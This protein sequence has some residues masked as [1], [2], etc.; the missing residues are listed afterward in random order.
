MSLFDF[1]MQLAEGGRVENLAASSSSDPRCPHAE[2]FFSSLGFSGA[3]G[4]GPRT[5]PS[6]HRAENGVAGITCGFRRP[7][8][9]N[10]TSTKRAIC[11]PWPPRGA[12]KTQ[13]QSIRDRRGRD[14]RNSAE[15]PKLFLDRAPPGGRRKLRRHSIAD[16]RGREL[17]AAQVSPRILWRA[18]RPS[19]S[20]PQTPQA[21]VAKNSREIQARGVREHAISQAWRL[22]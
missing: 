12:S 8:V 6:A 21:A 17:S 4:W 15:F 5:A 2:I 7:T 9:P 13:G 3:L 10:R 11:F 1:R 14:A 18:A 20:G 19:P 16:R 22:R